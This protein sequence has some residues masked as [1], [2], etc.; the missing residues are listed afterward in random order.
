MVY[1]LVQ[2]LRTARLIQ[3]NHSE[4]K[5]LSIGKFVNLLK[6]LDLNYQLKEKEKLRQP[7][8]QVLGLEEVV[9]G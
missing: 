5:K 2:R 1:V 9:H 7:G 8:L 3:S 4:W 6:K